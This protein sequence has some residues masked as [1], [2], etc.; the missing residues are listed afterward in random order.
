M[1]SHANTRAHTLMRNEPGP[2]SRLRELSGRGR[3]KSSAGFGKSNAG[4][5][6]WTQGGTGRRRGWCMIAVTHTRTERPCSMCRRKRRR[7]PSVS[8]SP[9]R[10]AGQ[11]R[12]QLH[13]GTF[14]N[15]LPSEHSNSRHPPFLGV[16]IRGRR[17]LG[18]SV[19]RG[20]R[21]SAPDPTSHPPFM[22]VR[23]RG[24]DIH[25]SDL[26]SGT[27]GS[28]HQPLHLTHHYEYWSAST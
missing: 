3:R 8:R 13:T 26:V 25:G 1:H 17:H 19:F 11:A 9:M 10:C 4:F 27:P 24:Q 7:T 14:P 22:G 18:I 20:L 21:I 23:I 16:R 6:G 5:R 2:A 12:R 15:T 28:V